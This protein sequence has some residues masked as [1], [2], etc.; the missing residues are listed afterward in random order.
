[1]KK[2]LLPLLLQAFSFAGHA[3]ALK[4][5][6]GVGTTFSYRL[7]LH[8]QGAPFELTVKSIRDTLKLGWQIRSL[9]TGTYAVSPEAWQNATS[10]NM[11]QPQPFVTVPL[12]NHQTFLMLSKKAFADL[13][14]QRRFTY[15]RTVYVLKDD[16]AAN[17]LLVKG[18]PLDVLHVVAQ[19]DPTE[20][21]ILNNATFPII[22]QIKH[23]PL[24]VDFL[25]SAVK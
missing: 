16:L 2:L 9:A 25:L 1:M 10:L 3:Q 6:V 20:F 7:D 24:G 19:N 5:A 11:A 12:P 4:P 8:G 14:A 15:D 17:P 23:N 18:Q 22:C 21:W 13:L